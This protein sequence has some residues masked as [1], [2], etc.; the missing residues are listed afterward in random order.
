MAMTKNETQYEKYLRNGNEI[1]KIYCST[2]DK[3][4]I[5][6]PRAPQQKY[7]D[8]YPEDQPGCSF[9]NDRNQQLNYEAEVIVY[10]ALEK[11]S[12]G[13]LIVLHSFEYTH[14]Q[15]YLGDSTHVKRR[16]TECKKRATNREGECDFVVITPNYFV[17]MEVKNMG[18]IGKQSDPGCNE[19]QQSQTLAKTFQK[20]LDQR[21]KIVEFVKRFCKRLT[22]LQFTVY[23]N[24]EKSSKKDFQLSKDQLSSIIFKEDLKDFNDWW[25]DN[26]SDLV[27]NEPL[28]P[29]FR[30][31][32]EDVRN[33]LLAIWCTDKTICDKSKC[34]LGKCIAKIDEQLRS[35]RFTFRSNN[36]EV[37]PSPKIVKDFLGIDNLTKQ[38]YDLIN[39]NEKFLWINGPAGAGKTVV[40]LA[41]MLQ[42]ALSSEDNKIVLF[43]ETCVIDDEMTSSKHLHNSLD[44]AGIKHDSIFVSEMADQPAHEIYRKIRGSLDENQVVIIMIRSRS[45]AESEW[46][47]KHLGNDIIRLFEGINVFF[48]DFHIQFRCNVVAGVESSNDDY[49]LPKTLFELSHFCHVWISCDMLQSPLLVIPDEPITLRHDS[50]LARFFNDEL[51]STQLVSL[52][53][54]LRNTSDLT[55]ILSVIRE[56]MIEPGHIVST[57][58][59]DFSILQAPGH[60]IHGPKTT[61][62]VVEMLDEKLINTIIVKELNELFDD[63]TDSNDLGILYSHGDT[64]TK[65]LLKSTL[66]D[67]LFSKN[68]TP[69]RVLSAY[70]KEWPAVIALQPFFDHNAERLTEHPVISFSPEHFYLAMSRARVKCTVILFPLERTIPAHFFPDYGTSI[71]GL[72]DKLTDFVE[73]IHHKNYDSESPIYRE[74]RFTAGITY[75]TNFFFNLPKILKEILR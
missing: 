2:G 75:P 60:Y 73:V 4:P 21:N 47:L 37:I 62:H 30:T 66:E 8:L 22:V 49:E 44:K 11:L 3:H 46:G 39:S 42:L 48:D 74:P 63:M 68:I 7:V 16:C 65:N 43:L 69:R 5:M 27:L 28:Q 59:N 71:R 1:F 53:K 13:D 33:L 55:K 56:H 24:F 25:T 10:R 18:H 19:D 54:N 14:F 36:P 26:I 51:S 57:F 50:R 20:S 17:I 40:L 31:K 35:G 41:K 29:E 45:N 64:D 34:S 23:P 67:I 32:H 38:Q 70:S 6:L 58:R 9:E 52:S 61:V 15:Y 72:L 12:G